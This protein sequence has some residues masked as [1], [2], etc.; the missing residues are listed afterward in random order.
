MEVPY[1]LGISIDHLIP[2]LHEGLKREMAFRC[3]VLGYVIDRGVVAV[4]HQI[5]PNFSR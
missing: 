2:G 3:Y 4:F 5:I 1:P